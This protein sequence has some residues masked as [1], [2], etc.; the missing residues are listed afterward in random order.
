MCLLSFFYFE[1][2]ISPEIHMKMIEVVIDAMLCFA[3]R[4]GIVWA[5]GSFLFPQS[6]MRSESDLGN[7][8]KQRF[9]GIFSSF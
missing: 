8:E 2:G 7:I 1:P 4:R 5:A 3:K 9:K 6:K